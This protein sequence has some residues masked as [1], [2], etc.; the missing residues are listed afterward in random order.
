V[1]RYAIRWRI[2]SI[3]P[4]AQTPGMV[5]NGN[6]ISHAMGLDLGNYRGSPIVERNGGLSNIELSFCA[7]QSRNSR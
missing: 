7:S 3:L 5:N 6:K 1:V 4:T 2:R